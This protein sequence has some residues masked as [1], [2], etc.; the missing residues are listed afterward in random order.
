MATTWLHISDLHFKE[1]DP[2]DRDKV[3]TALLR[4]LTAFARQGWR[5]DLIFVTGD[6]AYGGKAPEYQLASAF[7]DK[8]LQDTRLGRDK[9]F[10]VPG[11]HD[12]DRG[13]GR[14]LV[15]TL[16][17]E[18]ESKTYFLEG[19]EKLHITKKQA[20]YGKWYDD[21]FAGIRNFNRDST[22]SKFEVAEAGDQRIGVLLINSAAFCQDEF[23]EHKLWL[24]RRCLTAAR[25][26]VEAG[27]AGLNVALMHHP[28]EWVHKD[29]RLSVKASVTATVDCLL[30]GHLHDPDADA[31]SSLAGELLHLVAGA[32]Y[33]GSGWP[34]R[35][36]FGRFDGAAVQVFPIA[37]HDKPQEVWTL[38][39]AVFP[40]DQE[41]GY[42]RTY[43]IARQRP[44]AA[45]TAPAP[46][47]AQ[48][49]AVRTNVPPLGR[50]VVGREGELQA[51]SDAFAAGHGVVVITGPAGVGKS[52]LAREFAR[53][54]HAGNAYFIDAGSAGAPIDLIAAGR[55]CA[56][57]EPAAGFSLDDQC[58]AALRALAVTD[59]LLIYDNVLSEAAILP[60]APPQGSRCRVIMT[61][62]SDHWERGW[63]MVPVA[64]LKPEACSALIAAALGEEGAKVYGPAITAA[65]GGLPVQ[66]VPLTYA[67]QRDLRRGR[68]PAITPELQADTGRSFDQPY[69][70][71]S[72]DAQ[73]L[74]LA[75]L[76]YAA[77]RVPVAALR[78]ALIAGATWT[79][80]RFKAALEPAYELQ[81]VEGDDHLRMH[82]L[83]A[84][85]LRA[86]ESAKA[87]PALAT[88]RAEQARQF[89]AAAAASAENPGVGALIAAPLA[90]SADAGWW[91]DRLTTT[92]AGTAGRALREAGRFA[93]AQ[94]W[95]ER[96]LASKGAADAEGKIDHESLGVS[97]HEV[98]YCLSQQGDY[99]AATGWY[100]RAVK[101]AEQGDI[102]GRVDHES[103][104]KSLHLVGYCLSRQG[105]DAAAIGWYQRAVKE[106]EQGDIHGRVDHESLRVTLKS[107]I[108][109]AGRA[110]RADLVAVWQ[111]KLEALDG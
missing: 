73:F 87:P 94:A 20:A 3:L 96:G 108:V 44:A 6:I 105:D 62:L 38:D 43:P 103:L 100:E 70:R 75:T 2:Y 35:A 27:N 47:V 60:W 7:F 56:G 78:E 66:L 16:K 74:L 64:P 19:R 71:L 97:L 9:L 4:S 21:Y 106:K 12:V 41:Q 54:H 67:V 15:R 28:L 89:A 57:A 80:A 55:L 17:D 68:Q 81:F 110:G 13:E 36:F 48:P 107:A 76:A 95:F 52:E 104:G 51:I 39:P 37:Y 84:T 45:A 61:T 11:N 50:P 30:R 33:Q 26:D 34:N 5:P 49:A 82:Q 1:G 91:A 98:G 99:A 8:L 79:D 53:Q 31:V 102:H 109:V 85:Y 111:A 22:C 14:F 63:P 59:T 83:F 77:Q 88:V 24:G 72:E 69:S 86:Q 58:L 46:V 10:V 65:A 42:T 23:D 92:E 29:E 25:A 32:A 93:E 101:E 90:F 40:K 18:E